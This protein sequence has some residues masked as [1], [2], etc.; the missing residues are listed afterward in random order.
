MSE[1]YGICKKCKKK[2]REMMHSYKFKKE[3]IEK[4]DNKQLK[5]G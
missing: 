4:I 2:K 3:I 1:K 5:N